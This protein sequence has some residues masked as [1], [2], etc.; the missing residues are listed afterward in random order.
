MLDSGAFSDRPDARLPPAEAL[1]RQFYWEQLASEK[2]GC[3]WQAHA[4]VSYDLLIDETWVEGSK[5]KRRWD[6]KKAEWAVAETVAAAAYLDSQ[7]E[8]IAPRRLVLAAQGVDAFQYA[9]CAQD[10]LRFWKPGD[11]F[12]LGGW[13]ILGRM[14]SYLPVFWQSMWRVVPQLAA[15]GVRDVHIFGVLFEP[16]IAGLQWLCDQHGLSLSTDSGKPLKDAICKTDAQRKRAG[17][18]RP[19][20]RDNVQWWI[21]HLANIRQS[22]HYKEPPRTTA[23]RQEELFLWDRCC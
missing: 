19:Y 8:R 23:I 13:C 4:I 12:G 14:R 15:A 6:V 16:S 5:C 2:W 17:T 9:E 20:W 10:V 18:R 22:T 3:N 11:I 7:R 1:D 21:D